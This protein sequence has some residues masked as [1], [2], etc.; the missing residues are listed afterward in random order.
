M[1]K[2][3]TI[4]INEIKE[5]FFV[6]HRLNQDHAIQLSMLYDNG[7]KLPRLLVT[8]ENE[9]I[10][11]RHRLAALRSLDKKSVE[12]E[13]APDA[14]RATHLV[15]ALQA[16]LG[17]ALPPSNADII[18][19]ITQMLENGMVGSAIIKH[20]SNIWPPAV[21][22]RYYFDAQANLTKRRVNAAKDAVLEGKTV[23]EAATT[24]KIKIDTLKAA[25]GGNRKKRK[26]DTTE[27]KG[28]ITSIFRS[29]G[30][31]L[32]H[33][34]RALTQKFEDGE[35]SWKTAVAI[36]DHYDRC[37]KNTADSARDLR[38]RLEAMKGKS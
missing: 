21:A 17:G 7:T 23:Q 16:N 34:A 20:F 26:T 25:I 6:R 13:Y 1:A 22:R 10:D 29:R 28:T 37:V 30:S 12:V 35:I 33:I 11:G 4:N 5:S 32:G 9:L 2:Y 38:K 15:H 31:S 24:H 19:A 36:L 14:D 8:S 3:A 27:I 18:Y